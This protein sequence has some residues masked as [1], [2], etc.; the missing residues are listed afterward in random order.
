MKVSNESGN[1]SYN[2]WAV[3]K[4]K[5][6]IIMYSTIDHNIQIRH[7]RVKLIHFSVL[8]VH[9][10]GC[11]HDRKNGECTIISDWYFFLSPTTVCSYSKGT[12]YYVCLCVLYRIFVFGAAI[13]FIVLGRRSSEYCKSSFRGYQLLYM[14]LRNFSSS[15]SPEIIF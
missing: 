14:R 15:A 13:T 3:Q 2:N 10:K 6:K 11:F 4:K 9:L 12:Y 7:H 8:N 1:L 5:K